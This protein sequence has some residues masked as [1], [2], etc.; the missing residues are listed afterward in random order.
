MKTTKEKIEVMQAFEDGKKIEFLMPV[1][2]W[3]EWLPAGE[4]NWNWETNDYRI[5]AESKL[6]PWK[7]EEVPVGAL[8]K[9]KSGNGGRYM[10]V[11]LWDFG[12]KD[13]IQLGPPSEEGAIS[14]V[15][16]MNHW[17]HSIDHGKTWLPCGVTE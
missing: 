3:N 12:L 14:S 10:I 6:R 4:P 5:K 1:N 16:A 15:R 2:G 7:P 13:F 11:G 17:L 9:T 8:M